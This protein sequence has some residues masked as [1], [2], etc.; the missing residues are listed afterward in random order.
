MLPVY[1]QYKLLNSQ[2]ENIFALIANTNKFYC[3]LLTS[4]IG[5]TILLY[6]NKVSTDCFN[7]FYYIVV[8]VYMI[9]ISW[10]RTLTIHLYDLNTNTEKYNLFIQHNE[11]LSMYDLSIPIN[12]RKCM[13][14]LPLS[15]GVFCLAVLLKYSAYVSLIN[16]IFAVLYVA[17][18][19]L[20]YIYRFDIRIFKYL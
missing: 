7:Y 16:L 20:G 12:V 15:V 2:I 4:L 10:Y 17:M 5:A 19:Y 1:K 11:I 8:S 3:T 9:S 6:T 14:F 13:L 18:F